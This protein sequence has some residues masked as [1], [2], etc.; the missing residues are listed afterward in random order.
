MSGC[1]SPGNAPRDPRVDLS[2]YNEVF[3]A[4]FAHGVAVRYER[5]GLTRI[6]GRLISF[7]EDSLPGGLERVSVLEIGGGT[8]VIQLELLKRG[9]ARTTNLELSPEYEADAAR[10]IAQAGVGARVR[11]RVGVNIAEA[12]DAVEPAD[13]VVLHQV[14]CCY[15]DYEGLLSAAAGHARRAIV[16]SYPPRNL[17]TRLLLAWDTASMVLQRRA[18]RGFVH[19][20]EAMADVVRREGLTPV[21][22]SPGAVWSVLGAVRVT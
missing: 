10:L 12:P 8:G 1:C 17:L 16:F 19:P 6:E 2:R 21:Y 4:R 9:A 7:L 5:R 3:T 20:P 18:F 14:V 13:V 11:R 15:P 22:H